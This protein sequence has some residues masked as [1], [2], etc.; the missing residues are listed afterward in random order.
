MD[1]DFHNIYDEQGKYINPPQTIE[2]G[3][4]VWICSKSIILKGAEIAN[5]CVVG[6]G[7]IVTK[8]FKEEHCVIA[9]NGKYCQIVKEGI[10]WQP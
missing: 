1:A 7:S 5:G 6:A 10:N 2:I 3:D 9:G 4:N 8:Q